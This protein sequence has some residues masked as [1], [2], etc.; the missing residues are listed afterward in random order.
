VVV[1]DPIGAGASQ[2]QAIV[3]ETSTSLLSRCF[4]RPQ[5]PGFA[6]PTSVGRALAMEKSASEQQ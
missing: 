2:E 3:R 4:G 5:Y 1:G 6:G